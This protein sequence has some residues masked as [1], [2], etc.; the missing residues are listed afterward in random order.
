[1][2][3]AGFSESIATIATTIEAYYIPKQLG[4]IRIISNHGPILTCP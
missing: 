4:T 1:M 3:L 2:L